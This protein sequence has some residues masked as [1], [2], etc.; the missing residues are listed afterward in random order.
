MTKVIYHSRG[1]PGSGKTE[2]FLSNVK[3]HIGKGKLYL[4]ALPTHKL[5]VEIQERCLALGI[6]YRSINDEESEGKRVKSL[7]GVLE[8]KAPFVL[9][10]HSALSLLDDV[11][12]EPYTLVIDEVP[13]PL[14]IFSR[15]LSPENIKA[16]QAHLEIEQGQLSIR[17]NKSTEINA[18]L[19]SYKQS[20]INEQ[21]GTIWSELTYELYDALLH[22]GVVTHK[23]VRQ[24]QA[25][26]L[27]KAKISPIFDKMGRASAV[28]LLAAIDA[29][30][31]FSVIAKAKGFEF[32]TSEFEPSE[33]KYSGNITLLPLMDGAWSKGRALR[34]K[35]GKTNSVHIGEKGKQFVDEAIILAYEH[36]ENRRILLFRNNWYKPSAVIGCDRLRV[37]PSD[38]RGLNN[39]SDF[40][41]AILVY[42]GQANPNHV[43]ALQALAKKLAISECALVN[44]WHVTHKLERVLQDAARTGVRE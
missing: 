38:S 1:I 29:N 5:M 37:C 40:T 28:H 23:E 41:A 14:E 43:P 35:D 44:A 2:A 7:Q 20:V 24:R 27:C 22:G 4:M 31:L 26:V 13:P 36:S 6:P 33:F 10:T 9:T 17:P 18:L 32:K 39:L 3:K 42:S 34:D 30:G 19:K 25:H 8:R 21:I 11:Y 16:L 15:T 12:L